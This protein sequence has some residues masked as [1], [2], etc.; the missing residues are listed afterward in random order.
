MTTR[1]LFLLPG[2]GIGPEAMQEV[3][4]LIDFLNTEGIASFEVDE[5]LAGGC[6]YD[7]HGE[8]I[9][10]EDME[11]LKNV[12]KIEDYGK[13]GMMPVFAKS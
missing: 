1:S 4:S 8:A 11:I 13:D 2:D 12:E 10:E 9:S 7:A 5:G 6:A 3:R